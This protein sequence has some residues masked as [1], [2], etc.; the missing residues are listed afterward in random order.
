[1]HGVYIYI[2]YAVFHAPTTIQHKS[3]HEYLK[4]KDVDP[5]SIT[6][7]ATAI[8]CYY[9]EEQMIRNAKSVATWVRW[10]F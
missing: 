5:A 3:I 7:A 8:S 4:E 2:D 1:M 9:T 10:H 6:L